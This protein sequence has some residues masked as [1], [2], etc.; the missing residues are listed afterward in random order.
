MKL[1]H[2]LLILRILNTILLIETISF[3]LCVPVAYIYNESPAPFFWSA[4]TTFLLSTLFILISGKAK[5]DKFNDRDGY[6]LVIFGWIL[7]SCIGALPYLLSGEIKSVTDA[8][9]ESAPGFSTTGSSILPYVISGSSAVAT[10]MA[11]I[12]LVMA[13]G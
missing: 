5:G 11:V 2:P 9:F 10:C 7:F 12:A 3:L 13:I 8:L 6:L 4:T 1:F